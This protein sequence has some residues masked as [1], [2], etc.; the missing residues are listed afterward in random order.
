[1]LF[2]SMRYAIKYLSSLDGRNIAVLGTMKE[3]G[4]FSEKFHRDIGGIVKN[5]DID[6]LITVGDDAAFINESAVAN[7]VN[8]ENSYNFKTNVEAVDLINS[9][10]Q[11][12]D[13]YLVKASN[14]LNFKEIVERISK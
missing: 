6:I 3:L 2:R 12:N 4:E 13:N 1:M 8:K 7:E 14:S 5:E 10:K 9:L 11:D